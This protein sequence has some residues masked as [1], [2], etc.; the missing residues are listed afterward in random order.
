MAEIEES[1]GPSTDRPQT[2]P[3]PRTKLRSSPLPPIAEVPESKPLLQSFP[4]L[5]SLAK[6]PAF[7]DLPP[8]S[9]LITH[10][11]VYLAS[12]NRET[13]KLTLLLLLTACLERLDEALLPA[14]FRKI[15]PSLHSLP[16]SLTSLA[17]T[18]YLLQSLTSPFSAYIAAVTGDRLSVIGTGAVVWG[19]ST[20]AMGVA[21]TFWAVGLAR[22]ASAVGL[23]LALPCLCS[24]L[25]D[26]HSE[27]SRGL[28]FGSF[29][30][31]SQLGSLM[32]SLA[33]VTVADRMLLGMPGWRT[34]L[35]LVALLSLA[36]GLLLLTTELTATMRWVLPA[37][38]AKTGDYRV[39]LCP[40]LA[41][42]FTKQSVSASVACVAATVA[43]D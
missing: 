14:L 19:V 4:N 42:S 33:A 29:Q 11:Q 13:L 9:Q 38:L 27:T 39:I 3:P 31:A 16:F 17:F 30:A 25:A 12:I 18:R 41:S 35:N 21:S 34:A 5:S 7:S 6:L 8:P 24:L 23:A 26:I 28:A 40:V 36:L 20:A 37:W 15:A 32:G 22:V 1:V 10:L 2:K 43:D